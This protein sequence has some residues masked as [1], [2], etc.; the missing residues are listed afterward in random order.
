MNRQP[1]RR[2]DGLPTFAEVFCTIVFV[3]VFT[4]LVVTGFRYFT[5]NKNTSTETQTKE[6][7]TYKPT[8]DSLQ[9]S[10]TYDKDKQVRWY[11]FIDPDTHIEYLFND[12]G[13]VTP[14]LGADGESVMRTTLPSNDEL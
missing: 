13:G 9:I 10:Y 6:E 3:V 8:H 11:V 14:R 4:G 12:L 7:S 1:T 2:S 5:K